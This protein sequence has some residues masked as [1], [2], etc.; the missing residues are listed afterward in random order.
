VLPCDELLLLLLYHLGICL[1]PLE[2]ISFLLNHFSGL[3]LLGDQVPDLSEV[4]SELL[5]LC[6]LLLGLNMSHHSRLGEHVLG[7]KAVVVLGAELP[8]QVFLLFVKLLV[9][10]KVLLLLKF[11][12]VFH[13]IG[14]VTRLRDVR[15]TRIQVSL[16]ELS[17][18]ML[19]VNFV[20]SLLS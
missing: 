8:H 10:L 3:G 5:V 9:Q 19:E 6:P 14:D 12:H 7:L 4:V 11:Q 2:S 17:L 16:V 15:F 13:D 20:F 1:V 18:V